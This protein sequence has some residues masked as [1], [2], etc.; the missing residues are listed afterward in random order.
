MTVIQETRI[1]CDRDG[2]DHYSPMGTGTDYIHR[3]G[4]KIVR[5]GEAELHFCGI[6]C[7]AVWVQKQVG[8]VPA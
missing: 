2:C 5:D 1:K 6:N 3:F 7:Y 8:K 4:W